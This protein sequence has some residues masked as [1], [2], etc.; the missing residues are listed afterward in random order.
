MKY[1]LV[2]IGASTGGVSAITKVLSSL[3]INLPPIVV[4]QHMPLRFTTIMANNLNLKIKLNVKEAQHGD[5]L[6][7]GFVYIAPAGSHTRL[8]RTQAGLYISIVDTPK[9]HF[10]KPS[11]DVLFDSVADS[12]SESAIGVLLTGMGKDGAAG[13][14]KM[15]QSGAYTIAQDEASSTVYGMPREAALLGAAI[16]VLPI[17]E[18]PDTLVSLLIQRP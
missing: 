12:V 11:V 18:I 9:V 1:S 15:R 13:L 16:K 17:D 4:V 6:E 3:P 2:A 14:L 5:L 10:Q 7:R 8:V